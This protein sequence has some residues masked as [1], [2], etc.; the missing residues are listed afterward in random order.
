MLI[1]G[2]KGHALEILQIL[3]QLKIGKIVF[4]DDVSTDLI[5]IVYEKYRLVRNKEKV[6]E[7]FKKD[8]K[9]VLGAGNPTSRKI[10]AEFLIGLGGDLTTVQAPS[11]VVGNHKVELQPGLNIMCHVFI[12]NNT[13]IGLGTLLNT[14]CSVHHDVCIGNFCEISPGARLLGNVKVGNYCQVGTNATILPKVILG[15]NV[16]VGAGA[17]VTKNVDSNSMVV[18]VPAR[19]IKTLEPII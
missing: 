12:S 17:V 16:V 15:S 18:G 1:A 11:A 6:V 9:F 3:K 10:L 7:L 4:F 14:A 5:D 2:A 19:I 8:R 13:N